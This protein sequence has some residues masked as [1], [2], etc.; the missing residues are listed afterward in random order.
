M[1]AKAP[2]SVKNKYASRALETDL[3]ASEK[4]AFEAGDA[5]VT[6]QPQYP[7]GYPPQY[8]VQQP[9]QPAPTPPAQTAAP[10]P[11][12]SAQQAVA[13]TAPASPQPPA[14]AQTPTAKVDDFAMLTDPN[15]PIQ[16]VGTDANNDGTVNNADAQIAGAAPVD[17]NNQP[18]LPGGIVQPGT[19]PPVFKTASGGYT[20]VDPNAPPLPVVGRKINTEAEGSKLGNAINK[21]TD[22]VTDAISN[23]Q[24]KVVGGIANMVLPESQAA[25]FQEIGKKNQAQEA[26]NKADEEV[27]RQ[28][29]VAENTAKGLAAAGLSPAAPVAAQTATPAYDPAME[30]DSPTAANPV[31]PGTLPTAQPGITPSRGALVKAGAIADDASRVR[32]QDIAQPTPN[33]PNTGGVKGSPQMMGTAPAQATGDPNRT[34][35]NAGRPVGK[36]PQ[37]NSLTGLPMGYRTGDDLSGMDKGVQQKGVESVTAQAVAM[38][39][40]AQDGTLGQRQPL[41]VARPQTPLPRGSASQPAP[42]NGQRQVSAESQSYADK[43]KQQFAEVNA[44][45]ARSQGLTDA[46]VAKYGSVEKAPLPVQWGVPQTQKSEAPRGVNPNPLPLAKPAQVAQRPFFTGSPAVARPSAQGMSRVRMGR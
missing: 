23:A 40:A 9:G 10:A 5:R 31:Q 3:S 11:S 36:A 24:L 14:T 28:K 4:A 34:G 45:N 8:P 17:A 26:Q 41:P 42:V 21:G 19:N 13:Q 27:A 32:A 33:I 2:E 15:Q 35:F 25:V 38:G 20:N 7:Q 29:L 18:I 30:P 46:A 16:A 6:E 37:I 44:A 39:K 43:T 1:W 12:A 22:A